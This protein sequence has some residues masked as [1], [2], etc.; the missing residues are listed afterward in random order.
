MH[1]ASKLNDSIWSIGILVDRTLVLRFLLFSLASSF[2]LD[3]IAIAVCIPA[4]G[5]KCLVEQ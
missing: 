3:N 2:S 4:C 5:H 1:S